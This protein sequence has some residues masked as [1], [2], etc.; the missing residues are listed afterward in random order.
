MLPVRRARFV[1]DP[2]LA[3]FATAPDVCDTTLPEYVPTHPIEFVYSH[4]EKYHGIA[5]H[6]ARNRLHNI[7]ADNS[8]P[9]DFDLLFH[10]TGNVYRSDDRALIG[11]L[12]A[13][14]KTRGE[15]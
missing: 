12:T 11:S 3:Q 2:V 14:G 6:V 13:G 10:R 5:T 9:P 1:P 15:G 7:K 4:L 8:L